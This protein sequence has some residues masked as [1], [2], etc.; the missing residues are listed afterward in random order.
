MLFVDGIA[1]QHF[2]LRD[3]AAHAFGEED[4]VT[5]LDRRLHLAA[6]D[7]VRVGF[8]NRIELLGSRNLLA[9]EHTAARLIDHTGPQ[10]TKA[11]SKIAR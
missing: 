5:E 11:L 1:V 8:K 3:Q 7:Q 10:I 2:I 6:L 9:I 4:L